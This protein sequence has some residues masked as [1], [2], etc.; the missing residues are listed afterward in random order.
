MGHIDTT[1]FTRPKNPIFYE[2]ARYDEIWDFYI[3]IGTFDR[4]QLPKLQ[5]LEKILQ[6][7]YP[8]KCDFFKV[9]RIIE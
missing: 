6:K 9:L 5:M 4:A 2:N 7:K 8:K 3:I 1:D